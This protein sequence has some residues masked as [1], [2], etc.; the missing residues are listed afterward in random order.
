MHMDGPS[1]FINFELLWWWLVMDDLIYDLSVELWS[2][3]LYGASFW[4]WGLLSNLKR[5]KYFHLSIFVFV[6]CWVEAPLRHWVIEKLR[7]K[8]RWKCEKPLVNKRNL[9]MNWGRRS[10]DARC[11]KI[12]EKV[13]FNIASEATYFYILSGQK[14][15]KN[16]KN[17]PFW[18]IFENLKLAVKQCYQTGKF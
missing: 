15:I 5:K 4:G 17:G 7:W 13:S 14:F 9:R 18:P 3:N 16:A 12:T 8:Q 6:E 10:L 2:N 11:L 1:R